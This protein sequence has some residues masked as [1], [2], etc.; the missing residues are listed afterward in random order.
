MPVRETQ[1]PADLPVAPHDL[2]GR[3]DPHRP[4][5]SGTAARPLCDT[6]T[7]DT[8]PVATHDLYTPGHIRP[9]QAAGPLGAFYT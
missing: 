3:Q 1:L 7:L 5:R 2:Y 4:R 9:P 6:A 8:L